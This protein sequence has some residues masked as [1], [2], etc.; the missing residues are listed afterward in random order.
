MAFLEAKETENFKADH[1]KF[2]DF[3]ID[4]VIGGENKKAYIQDANREHDVHTHTLTVSLLHK[5]KDGVMYLTIVKTCFAPKGCE[6]DWDKVTCS[7]QIYA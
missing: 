6:I 5:V 7:T 3:P 4:M 1:D 2:F